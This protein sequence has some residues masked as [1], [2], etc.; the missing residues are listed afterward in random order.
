MLYGFGL[1]VDVLE[2]DGKD[3]VGPEPARRKRERVRPSGLI[4]PTGA[5]LH[6]R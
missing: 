6:P 4:L 2:H 3:R 1:A 5:D